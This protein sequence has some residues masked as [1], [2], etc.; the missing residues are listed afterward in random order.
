MCP[1][2]HVSGSA[3]EVIMP[4]PSTKEVTLVNIIPAEQGTVKLIHGHICY[5]MPVQKLGDITG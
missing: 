5:N 3:L 2:T 1:S 4:T